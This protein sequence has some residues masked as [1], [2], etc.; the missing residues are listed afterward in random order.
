M[1][2]GIFI[3]INDPDKHDIIQLRIA[4]VVL[5]KNSWGNNTDPD[6]MP[7]SA[8]SDLGLHCLPMSHKKGRMIIHITFL[9]IGYHRRIQYILCIDTMHCS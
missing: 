5:D 6:Q 4:W 1:F 8:T 3:Y 2:R 9:D 7:R